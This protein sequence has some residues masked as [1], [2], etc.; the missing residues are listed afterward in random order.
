VVDERSLR[1]LY[2]RGF[3]MVVKQAQPWSLMC[4][5]NKVNGVYCSENSLLNND[6]LRK[7]WGFKGVVMT[8]WGATNDRVK[9]I[10]AGMDLEMPGSHGVHN[11]EIKQALK[12]KV[13]S[14]EDVNMCGQRML[15]F[16]QMGQAAAKAQV[17]VDLDEHHEFAYQVAMQCAV[18][19]KNQDNCLPLKKGVSVAVIGDFGKEH[20]RYQGMG[21]S[22]V[23]SSKIVT[24]WDRLSDH[25]DEMHYAPG[26]HADDDHPTI[27]DQELLDQAVVAAMKAEVCLLCV[28]LPEI[29]E[30]EG[31]DRP[32]LS[33]PAQHNALVAAVCAVNKNVVVI[34]SNGGAVELPWANRPKAIL[35]GYLLGQAGGQAIADLVFGVQSPCGKLAE[36]FPVHVSDILANKY[37]PGTRDTVEH[38]EGLDVGYRYFDS[39]DR[40]VRYPFGHGLSYSEFEFTGLELRVLQDEEMSKKVQVTLQI[41]N[42]GSMA[43]AEVVQCYIRDC[44]ASVYRPKQELKSFSKVH[45][46]AG[47]T[48]EVC[49]TL[50]TDAFS[51]Y[52]VGVSGWVVEPGSFEIRIGSSSRDIR[53]LDTIDL[54][55]GKPASPLAVTT[56]PPVRDEK[57]K[58]S[59]LKDVNDSTFARRF[60]SKA[61]LLS[62]YDK[63]LKLHSGFHR[64]SLLKEVAKSRW[65][66]KILLHV[67]SVEASKEIK[68]GPTRKRQKRM[69]KANVENLPLRVL[70]LFSKGTLSFWLLD[71]IIA[72]MNFCRR[73]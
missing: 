32:R 9:A 43:A 40:P 72:S 57:G 66:G 12:D 31:F 71:K 39:A 6:I 48:K 55:T 22:Q 46:E 47:E 36:T 13:L 52:D 11:R 49:M 27:I 20:P 14:M 42:V 63:L 30:S 51:F 64:N 29:M 65:V 7:E 67:V 2:L 37:F 41:K 38:R 62:M 56:Y 68:R 28:G 50:G 53:L 24:V 4:A 15:N 69:I 26:Y 23:K 21:S 54:Q 60:G 25:T 44:E 45:L 34:L 70:V 10:Q 61:N 33:M 3:E 1:E 18:L 16:L 73:K 58:H 59:T 17:E 35:E 19:L 5:Y 8:D